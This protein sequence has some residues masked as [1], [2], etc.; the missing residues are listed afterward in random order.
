MKKILIGIVA[1]VVAAGIGTAV[2]F[3]VRKKTSVTAEATTAATVAPST[4]VAENTTAEQTTTEKETASKTETLS[5]TTTKASPKKSEKLLKATNEDFENLAN[6]LTCSYLTGAEHM[7]VDSSI[8]QFE[9]PEFDCTKKDAFENIRNVIP[10]SGVEP[11]TYTYIFGA[12]TYERHFGLNVND[13][14]NMIAENNKRF[15]DPGFWGYHKMNAE[16]VRIIIEEIFN[17]NDVLK[18]ENVKDHVYLYNGSCY[19]IVGVN[20]VDDNMVELAYSRNKQ[21]N[22]GSY[23]VIFDARKMMMYV[24]DGEKQPYYGKV[25]AECSLKDYNGMRLWSIRKVGK[26]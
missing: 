25:K 4:T 3:G 6:I 19:S 11:K 20:G 8:P 2:F 15:N 18:L 26:A 17:L 23:E 12:S 24:H 14:L 16:N 5:K 7:K 1:V 13:P 9:Y 10:I 21:K 22:D